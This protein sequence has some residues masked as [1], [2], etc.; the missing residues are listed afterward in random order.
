MSKTNIKKAV[1]N[2]GDIFSSEEVVNGNYV[3]R[4][5]HSIIDNDIYYQAGPQKEF[6]VF[7]KYRFRFVLQITNCNYLGNLLNDI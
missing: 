4:T 5:I 1:F 7:D 2:V 3:I 6:Y